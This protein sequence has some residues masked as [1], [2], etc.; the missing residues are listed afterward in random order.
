MSARSGNRYVRNKETGEVSR[1]DWMAK[2]HRHPEFDT[3]WEQHYRLVYWSSKRV[4]HIFGGGARDYLGFLTLRFFRI[5]SAYD[6]DKGGF[7]TFYCTHLY[8]DTLRYC[9]RFES[10]SWESYCFGKKICNGDI[11]AE[12][13][14]T[15]SQL[16]SPERVFYRIPEN[17]ELIDEVRKCFSSDDDLWRYITTG[18]S[19]RMK[20]VVFLYYKRG[21][22]YKS[23]GKEYGVSKQAIEQVLGRAMERIRGR[24]GSLEKWVKIFKIRDE[25]MEEHYFSEIGSN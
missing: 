2:I 25:D 16:L 18:L 12:R 21:M 9:V 20:D 14:R 13:E 23:I 7:S 17:D 10:D 24:M 6:P 3:Y 4:S 19:P 22:T 11:V 5:V 1:S 8:S 15:V